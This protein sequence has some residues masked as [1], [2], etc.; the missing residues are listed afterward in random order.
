MSKIS[1]WRKIKLYY[2]YRTGIINNTSLL[3]QNGFRIDRVK[4]IYTVINVPTEIF[5][6]AYDLKTSDINRVSQSF[7]TDSVRTISKILNDIGINELYK[8]YETRKVDKYSYLIILGYKFFDTRKVA[9]LIFLRFLPIIGLA[10]LIYFISL[11]V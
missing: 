11:Y 5:D 4:R 7:L 10:L 8:I 9:D 3:Q 6:E 1:L 2:Q